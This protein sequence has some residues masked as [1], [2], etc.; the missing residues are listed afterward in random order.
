MRRDSEVEQQVLRSL[1]LTSATGS[2][3]ICVES[4]DGVVTLRGT[5]RSHRSKSAIHSATSQAPGVR[6]VVNNIQLKGCE[7]SIRE[8]SRKALPI[9]SIPHGTGSLSS[10]KK[11][12]TL[13]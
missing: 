12:V 3:E 2:K 5:V 9:K 7:P 4:C 11:S 13:S 10:T 8:R 6:G 1:K